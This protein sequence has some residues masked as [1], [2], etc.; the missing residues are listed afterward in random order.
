MTKEEA[1]EKL[2]LPVGT[3]P[4]IVRQ[5]FQQM[6]NEFQVQI[7][8]AFREDMRQKLQTRLMELEEARKLLLGSEKADDSGSLP[9]TEKTFE[10]KRTEEAK[11]HTTQLT[12]QQALALFGLTE[13]QDVAQVEQH[14]ASHIANLQQQLSTSP[15]QTVKDAYQIEI[16]KA[17]S[18][19][20][21]IN[22]WLDKRK[23][24]D[25][26]KEEPSQQEQAT[27]T[28]TSTPEKPKSK[29][30][31]FIGI[32][33]AV[34]VVLAGFYFLSNQRGNPDSPI[35]KAIDAR[36]DSTAWEAALVGG[37]K[38]SYEH[39]I[40]QYPEGIFVGAAK[41]SLER[42]KGS[43]NLATLIQTQKSS[44]STSKDTKRND[45]TSLSNSNT[46]KVHFDKDEVK[47]KRQV[48]KHV[49]EGQSEE[50]SGLD[51]RGLFQKGKA[52]YDSKNYSEAV[53]FFRPAAEQGHSEA[54]RWLGYLYDLGLGIERNYTEAA[55]WYRKA[56]N[57]QNATAQNNL[58]YLYYTGR[59]VSR[60]YAEA[61]AWYNKAISNGNARAS[62]NLG[63][64][65]SK[66]HGVDQSYTEAVKW[67]RKA[68][69]EGDTFGQYSLAVM[70]ETG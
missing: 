61:I 66:G 13:H 30:G 49:S 45:N 24:E 38:A 6:H 28:Y 25:S 4:H 29:T 51:A 59:G 68:A 16:D 3:N 63:V 46:Q 56:T 41:D 7:D 70:Y 42:I 14:I 53:K 37:N 47:N 2:E 10:Q 35:E 36:Q 8:G 5:K 1:Y 64:M 69:D 58:G 55:N 18:A 65:Y 43:T 9:H 32:A 44:S 50:I 40:E 12:L 11:A 33:A 60:D 62:N 39:Y 34:I 52:F 26:Q 67:Y 15:L 20:K 48:D 27:P 21:V 31:L 54:Q 23:K 57:Q 22:K 19:K 17:T